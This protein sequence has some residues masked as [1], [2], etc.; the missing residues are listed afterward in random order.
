MLQVCLRLYE[1]GERGV[2]FFF[3]VSLKQ[4]E[5]KKKKELCNRAEGIQSLHEM[6]AETW[7]LA[8]GCEGCS[9]LRFSGGQE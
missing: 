8:G 9:E 3:F 6:E 5:E 2:F 1:I 4:E 7:S